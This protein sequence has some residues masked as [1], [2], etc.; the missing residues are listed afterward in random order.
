MLSGITWEFG[1]AIGYTANSA[2][3]TEMLLSI[4][5][6]IFIPL[7]EYI[8]VNANKYLKGEEAAIWTQQEW[9][10]MNQWYFNPV[11]N[12]ISNTSNQLSGK[13]Q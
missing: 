5:W 3:Q 13:D 10:Y 11:F 6:D 7:I 8:D 9:V 4:N 1:N 12:F 2:Y